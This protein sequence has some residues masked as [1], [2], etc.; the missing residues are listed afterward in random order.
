MMEW[1]EKN[2]Y[3]PMNSN[4]KGLTYYEHY[5]RIAGWFEGRD[6]L[7]PPREASLDPMNLC[8]NNC[9]YCNSQRYLRN[10]SMRL[11]RWGIDYAEELLCELAKWGV[12]GLCWG[13]GGEATLNIR[14]AEMNREAVLLGLETAI[15]TNGVLL[16]DDLIDSLML[17]KWIGVSVDTADPEVY[18]RIRGTDDCLKVWQNIG[19]L[20]KKK[21]NT[22]LGVRALVLPENLDNLLTTCWAARGNGADFFH[23][24][25][26]DLERK[27][28]NCKPIEFDTA[29]VNDILEQ[30]HNFETEDFAVY[31]VRHK[32]DESFHA[33]HNFTRCWASP[34]VVQV[35]TDK[36]RYVCVDHRLEPRF[37]VPEWGSIAHRQLLEGINP[38]EECSRCTW[39]AYN[40]QIEEVVLQDKMHLN[41]P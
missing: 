34:L 6:E 35:C 26:V 22:V 14:L 20:A 33:K 5:K 27:D 23:V 25:P 11:K 13:G 2:Y 29:K 7:P 16:D 19:K 37:E 36:K 1:S 21:N 10:G 39:S 40:R 3:N 12:K 17:C 18:R 15:V 38:T 28:L 9:Y 41:F 30:C 8:N 31:T 4:A 24:R 32:F